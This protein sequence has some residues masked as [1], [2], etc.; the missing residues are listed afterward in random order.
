MKRVVD[1]RIGTQEIVKIYKGDTLI[2]AKHPPVKVLIGGSGDVQIEPTASSETRYCS[3]AT[4]FG[5]FNE[6]AVANAN[7]IIPQVTALCAEDIDAVGSVVDI[8]PTSAKLEDNIRIGVLANPTTNVVIANGISKIAMDDIGSARDVGTAHAMTI[9][10]ITIDELA[11]ARNVPAKDAH[12]NGYINIS[13]IACAISGRYH[14]AYAHG[15]ILIDGSSIGDNAFTK[16][17]NSH[18]SIGINSTL[19]DADV[20][21]IDAVAHGDVGVESTV[22]VD[23]I[24]PTDSSMITFVDVDGKLYSSSGLTVDGV[25]Y[26]HIRTDAI[27]QANHADTSAAY[28]QSNIRTDSDA[29]AITWIYPVLHGDM[30]TIIQARETDDDNLPNLLIM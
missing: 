15:D 16:K 4:M 29:G 1:V 19:Y 20:R 25:A 24:E 9:S 2:W 27:L 17:A 21:M 5:A 30:L 3:D 7:V 13:D 8:V 22:S 28:S 14:E 6:S 23:C 10:K 12:S 18:S 26:D 11:N